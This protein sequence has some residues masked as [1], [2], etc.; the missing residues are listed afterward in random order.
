MNVFLFS[1]SNWNIINF[2]YNLIKELKKNN[3][4]V[5]TVSQKDKYQND[6]KK[7]VFKLININYKNRKIAFLSDF[8]NLILIVCYVI[9]FKPSIFISFNIKPII[10]S[11]L[12]SKL[13]NISNII[14][15]TGL[16]TVF[17]KK[18]STLVKKIAI[19]LYYISIKKMII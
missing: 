7:N 14:T 3:F 16:G 17:E 18:T 8:I 4:K 19:F 12:A 6:L 10:L 2:R 11:G 9:K 15:I 1:K 5:I 13:F